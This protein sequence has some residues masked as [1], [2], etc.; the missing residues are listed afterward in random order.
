MMEQRKAERMQILGIDMDAIRVDKVLGLTSHYL[1]RNKFEYIAFVNT[2]AALAGHEQEDFMAFMSQA[3]LV[4]P[5]DNNIED[6]LGNRTWIEEETSYQ[7]EFFRRLLSRMNRQRASVYLMIEKEEEL[8]R[9]KGIFERKYE[10]IHL[11]YTL[12]QNEENTDSMVNDINILAP[13][14]LLICGDYGRI[15]GFMKENG[16]KINAGICFCME[17]ILSDEEEAVPDWVEKFHLVKMY[18]W[19]YKKP[20][21][22]WHDVLFKHT[23]KKNYAEQKP[24]S[25]QDDEN[26]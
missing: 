9:L 22:F 17:A 25:V 11:E 15:C 10:K 26:S 16:C 19:F 12:W 24:D 13:E 7:A 3:A 5:G 2:P 6:A 18:T 21:R 23:M 14:L 4:L 8:E 1:E 20:L